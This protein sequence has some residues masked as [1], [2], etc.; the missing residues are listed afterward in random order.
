MLKHGMIIYD[1]LY[2]P[3]P[4]FVFDQ[5]LELIAALP[6]FDMLAEPLRRAQEAR[7]ASPVQSPDADY[8]LR[9]IAR[10]FPTCNTRTH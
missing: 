9:R 10:H 8:D 2:A 3:A 6:Y 1:A 5:P 4:E 7:F